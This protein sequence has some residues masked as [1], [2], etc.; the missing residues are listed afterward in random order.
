MG[1]TTIFFSSFVIA[2]S[3]AMMPGP[4]F[5]ATMLKSSKQGVRAGPLIVLGHGTLEAVLVVLLYA[6][7]GGLFKDHTI[8]GSIGIAGGAAL[9]WMAYEAFMFPGNEGARQ[10]GRLPGTSAYVAGIVTSLSNPYWIVWWI[11]IGLSYIVLSFPFGLGGVVVFYAGHILADLLWYS[12]VAFSFGFM[13]RFM[14]S[15]GFRVITLISGVIFA[16]F[17]VYFLWFG[18]HN[19]V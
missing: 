9:L 19:L 3:G 12:I 14:S 16:G 7:L 6:G 15:N 13:K 8:M 10:N 5:T 17:A 1:L 11:T 2:F 18:L 4:M